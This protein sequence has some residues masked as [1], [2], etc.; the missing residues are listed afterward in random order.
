[1]VFLVVKDLTVVFEDCEPVVCDLELAEVGLLEDD[2][3]DIT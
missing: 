1:V 3:E 2:F